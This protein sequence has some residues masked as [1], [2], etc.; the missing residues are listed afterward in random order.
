MISWWIAPAFITLVLALFLLNFA[1][2]R[3]SVPFKGVLVAVGAI[4]ISAWS[5]VFF[6]AMYLVKVFFP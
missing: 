5:L 4:W 6:L 3:D 2:T 1:L